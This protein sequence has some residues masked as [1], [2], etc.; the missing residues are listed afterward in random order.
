MLPTSRHVCCLRGDHTTADAAV[1]CIGCPWVCCSVCLRMT[2][3]V[4]L[5]VALTA[6]HAASQA[7][8]AAAA[9]AAATLPPLLHDGGAHYQSSLL[10]ELHREHGMGAAGQVP[11]R[12]N[13]NS[14]SPE[15]PAQ[16]R[17]CV[18][19][20][21]IGCSSPSAQYGDAS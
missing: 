15:R 13:A 6:T 7:A 11:L 9:A 14:I 21:K 8:P 20:T 19:R 12:Q 1:T 10:E 18:S 3:S 17:P 16:K 2:H 5:Q 4:L